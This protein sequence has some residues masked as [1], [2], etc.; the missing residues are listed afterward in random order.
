MT[1]AHS[2]H[3]LLKPAST[4]QKSIDTFALCLP[5]SGLHGIFAIFGLTGVV[6]S[7][8]MKT[9]LR[10]YH[11]LSVLIHWAVVVMVVVSFISIEIAIRLSRS[12]ALRGMLIKTHIV[13]GQLLFLLNLIRLSIFSAFGTPV[14]DGR[15]FHQVHAMR[16][17]HALLYGSIGFLACSGSLLAVAYAAGQTVLG[18]QIPMILSPIGM[19]SLR[20]LHSAVSIAFIFFS[21]V[22]AIGAIAMH[23]FAGRATLTKMRVEGKVSD[24]I[25]SPETESA[26]LRIDAPAIVPPAAGES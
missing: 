12:D 9:D 1:P 3:G 25:T 11:P 10:N 17:M 26:Y 24:Y 18:I 4:L 15:D 7:L 2:Q 16:F 6:Y 21:F 20:E 5:S 22:H 19:S 14:P 13:A 23:Y 8:G